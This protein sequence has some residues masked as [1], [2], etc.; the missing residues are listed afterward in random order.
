MKIKDERIYRATITRSTGH[1]PAVGLGWRSDQGAVLGPRA[2]SRMQP[3]CP[4][5]FMHQRR[6]VGLVVDSAAVLGEN[7]LG[8]A[9]DEFLCAMVRSSTMARWMWSGYSRIA[10]GSFSQPALR[11][12]VLGRCVGNG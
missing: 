10:V 6:Q 11:S 1:V 5:D 3:Q 4:L 2:L 12:P 8:G 9:L 7:D